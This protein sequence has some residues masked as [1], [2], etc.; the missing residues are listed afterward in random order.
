MKKRLL[1]TLL[2]VLLL[3]A[4][5][6]PAMAV[7]NVSA[8]IMGGSLR[9]RQSPSYQARIIRTYRTGTVVT[10]L[11]Q[12]A[13]WCQ[14]VTPDGRTGYMD[15]RYLYIGGAPA[16]APSV[17]TWTDVNANYWVTS[18]NGRGVRMRSAP[19]KNNRN[20]TGLYPVGR[21]AFVARQSN[22]GWSYISIDG[23]Y[24]YMMSE[25]LTPSHVDP[26]VPTPAPVCPTPTPAPV[27][28][29]PTPVPADILSSITLSSAS[30]RVG[31]TLSVSACPS[32]ATYMVIW[33][34]DDNQL[35]STSGQ[36]TVAAGDAGHTIHVHVSGTGNSAGV[37][38]EKTTNTVAVALTS[39]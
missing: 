2:A 22:D 20:V 13:G 6:L 14:V 15:E 21:T 23:K 26:V 3:C 34:R 30:P 29:T 31:D 18:K 8:T 25:F 5:A 32:G 9:L 28:P 27:C 17:R 12:D 1:C 38:I 4:H 39:P 19:A 36:Y 24:G 16:P 10:V 35:L 11:S 33:Y 37:I 7:T